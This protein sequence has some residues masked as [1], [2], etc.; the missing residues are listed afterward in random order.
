MILFVALIKIE[1][2]AQTL[3]LKQKIGKPRKSTFRKNHAPIWLAW[4][5][6][7][8]PNQKNHETPGGNLALTN[9]TK[10]S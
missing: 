7:F 10:S 6:N 2:V 5:F 9:Q 4:C 3:P 8:C 1:T